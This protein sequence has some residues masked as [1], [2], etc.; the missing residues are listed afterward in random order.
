MILAVE[1]DVTPLSLMCNVLK[2]CV[3]KIYIIKRNLLRILMHFAV[4][5]AI[6]NSNLTYGHI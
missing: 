2:T 6:M 5:S 4:T 1:R 3:F